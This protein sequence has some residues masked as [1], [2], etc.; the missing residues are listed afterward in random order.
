MYPPTNCVPTIRMCVA[1][2]LACNRP[3]SRYHASF[4]EP[5]LQRHKQG[6]R[7][8]RMGKARVDSRANM[9]PLPLPPPGDPRRVGVPLSEMRWTFHTDASLKVVAFPLRSQGVCW[10]FRVQ[11]ADRCECLCCG[12]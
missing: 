8:R 6:G 4:L 1:L 10:G 2:R 12:C 3:L 5:M 9:R 7:T 11:E